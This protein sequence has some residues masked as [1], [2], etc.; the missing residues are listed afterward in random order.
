MPTSMRK[1]E[2]FALVKTALALPPLM[3]SQTSLVELFGLPSRIS[4]T[5]NPFP[6]P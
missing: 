1:E 5:V 2:A 3:E 4:P 6:M